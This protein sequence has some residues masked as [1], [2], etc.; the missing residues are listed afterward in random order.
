MPGLLKQDK[1]ASVN[2]AALEYDGAAGKATYTGAVTLWQGDTSLRADTITIDQQKGDLVATG[3]AVLRLSLENGESV[4]QAH[5]IR[6]DDERRLVTY[7]SPPPST[8]RGT[9]T[10]PRAAQAGRIGAAPTR[11]S[12]PHLNGPQGDLSAD[13]LELFLAEDVSALDRLEAYDRVTTT[14]SP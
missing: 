6:Y 4:G 3:N 13:R 2:A 8:S 9:S 10:P 11:P 7:L 12:Q 1:P 5:E 14:G